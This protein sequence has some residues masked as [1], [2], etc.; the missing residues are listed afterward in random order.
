MGR[1]S[2]TGAPSRFRT[3]FFYPPSCSQ[4]A[5]SIPILSFACT[6]VLPTLL[7][8]VHVQARAFGFQIVNAS[9]EDTQ[10]VCCYFT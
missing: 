4:P 10:K 2:R 6:T 8:C 3:R 1:G 9:Q 5:V 7:Q